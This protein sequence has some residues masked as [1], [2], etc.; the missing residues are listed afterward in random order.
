MP[1]LFG[2]VSR[3]TSILAKYASCA[4]NFT[5]VTDQILAKIAPENGK[6]TYSHGN[7]LFHYI[8]EDR[9]IY[10]CITD[11][12]FERARAFLY[13]N[14]IKQR[15]QAQFGT[16]AQTA[17]P[18][19]MNSDFSRIMANQMKHFS[20]SRDVDVVSRVQGEIDELKNIMVRNIDNI[21]ARGERIELLIHKTDNLS[22]QS[23]QF[24]KTSRNLAR[25]LF[26]KNVKL[27]ATIVIVLVVIIYIIVAM[28]CG[29]LTLSTCVN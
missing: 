2:V 17:L 28:S 26:W 9:I 10:L 11:D 5:E 29:G 15:F 7:Y 24:R 1:I 13:L 16:R 6:L 18:Y 25:S 27:M 14:D 20:E 21:A 23:V 8:S 19:S 4:G 22:S 3:G 12:D